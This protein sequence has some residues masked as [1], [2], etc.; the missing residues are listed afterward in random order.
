MNIP[1][2]M[3]DELGAWNNGKGID[4]ES[5]IGCEGNFQLAVGYTTLFNPNFVE[6][7]DYILRCDEINDNFISKVR[8]WENAGEQKPT[9]KGIEW[10]IN[11]LHIADIH[12]G[13]C[14]DISIDK[15]LLL[16]NTLKELYEAKLAYKFPNK[17]CIVEFYIP[18]DESLLDDYQISFWQKKHD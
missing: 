12:H 5:W 13:G 1:E 9:S 11:H 7:E 2:S 3:K 16:G 4:L 8:N 14:E 6:F 17:P 18:E 15:I 10:V